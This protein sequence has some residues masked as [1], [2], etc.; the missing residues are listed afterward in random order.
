MSF[1]DYCFEPSASTNPS[2]YEQIC[3]PILGLYQN[4]AIKHVQSTQD[5]LLNT[6]F[7]SAYSYA[8]EQ[9]T[10]LADLNMIPWI[11][12]AYCGCGDP[13]TALQ[14][15]DLEGIVNDPAEPLTGSNI[16]TSHLN[17][18]VRPYPQ[19]IAGTPESWSYNTITG[20]FLLAWST[21]SPLGV[22]R[23]TDATTVVFVPNLDYPHGYQVSIN[24][25][26]VISGM[27]TQYLAIAADSGASSVK[28]TVWRK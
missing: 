7:G 12:W 4:L 24:N 21:T 25:G 15:L 23:A 18:L 28:V 1:H 19:A 14:P 10:D 22:I 3:G 16:N 6:E 26:T 2:F 13:T 17:A 11:S 27:G 8:I 20:T 5:A 9:V